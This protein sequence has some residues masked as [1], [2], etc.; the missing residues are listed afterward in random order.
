MENNT[1]PDVEAGT[2]PFISNGSRFLMVAIKGQPDKIEISM[3]NLLIF[4]KEYTDIDLGSG[5]YQILGTFTPSEGKIDFEVNPDWL[6]IK[7]YGMGDKRAPCYEN[8]F[9]PPHGR[10]VLE[11]E[12]FLSLLTKE[13]SSKWPLESN[14]KPPHI[15]S[16]HPNENKSKMYQEVLKQWQSAEEKVMPKR[17]LI[18]IEQ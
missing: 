3:N 16:D 10:T 5:Q 6:E 8:H 4:D 13:A 12:A 11:D 17:I 7:A 14:P 9:R 2:H 15:Y 18:L 1:T